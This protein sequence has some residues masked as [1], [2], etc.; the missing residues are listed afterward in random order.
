MGSLFRGARPIPGGQ[1]TG[2][3]E[4]RA[5]RDLMGAPVAH[6]GY[7]TY[8]VGDRAPIGER[9]IDALAR[10]WAA[11]HDP[12]VTRAILRGGGGC[13]VPPRDYDAADLVAD[14]YA[15]VRFG[16]ARIIAACAAL[17]AP[18]PAPVTHRMGDMAEFFAA[19]EE[20]GQ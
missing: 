19:V 12:R 2:A 10:E 5:A 17:G 9:P 1:F 11:A 15:H 8:S 18:V 14:G 13:P 20:A 3:T 16:R 6:V 4:G 7:V